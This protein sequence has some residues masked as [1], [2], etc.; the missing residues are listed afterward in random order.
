MAIVRC[1]SP[2]TAAVEWGA[3]VG[4]DSEAVDRGM[5]EV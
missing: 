1:A 4:A 3:A 2:E 5:D